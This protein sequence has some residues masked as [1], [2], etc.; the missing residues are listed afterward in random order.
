M[1]SPRDLGT[2]PTKRGS[3]AIGRNE[4]A[5]YFRSLVSKNRLKIGHSKTDGPR[6]LPIQLPKMV[7]CEDACLEIFAKKTTTE[8][9][10]FF[11][12]KRTTHLEKQGLELLPYPPKVPNRRAL[13][14]PERSR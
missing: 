2:A 9:T 4:F 11:I 7:K 8:K 14:H 6:Q 12:I 10:R 3:Q 13:Q 1:V 5:F